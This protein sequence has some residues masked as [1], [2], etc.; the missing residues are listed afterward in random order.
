MTFPQTLSRE[1][2]IF[3]Y[4]CKEDTTDLE[5]LRCRICG[6]IATSFDET[7]S[8]L[9]WHHVFEPTVCYQPRVKLSPLMSSKSDRAKPKG[10]DMSPSKQS[11]SALPVNDPSDRKDL[12]VQIGQV[13]QS[14]FVSSTD[15]SMERFGD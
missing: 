13:G 2:L 3:F 15:V 10:R 4:D 6:R 1:L 12:K 14:I 9:I 5:N 8:N 11:G 7:E